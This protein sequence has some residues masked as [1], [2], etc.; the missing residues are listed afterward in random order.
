MLPFRLRR[1]GLRDAGRY[2]HRVFRQKLLARPI[3]IVA[4]FPYDCNVG[5]GKNR[6]GRVNS[7]VRVGR[8]GQA[9]NAGT[10]EYCG[11]LT[12]PAI[13]RSSDA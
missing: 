5:L 6:S 2:E 13:R 9:G 3:H 8:L 11:D 12:R 7:R 1:I 4:C 10:T